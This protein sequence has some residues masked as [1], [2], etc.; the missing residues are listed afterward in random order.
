MAREMENGGN[1]KLML[2]DYLQ[3]FNCLGTLVRL[4]HPTAY[5]VHDTR[6][7]V[8]TVFMGNTF[9]SGV[10]LQVGLHSV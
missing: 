7:S 1:V 2:I 3:Y 6:I 4:L 8:G 9:L 5:F 10:G